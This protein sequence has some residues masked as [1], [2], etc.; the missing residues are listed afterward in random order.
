MS[1]FK[2][3]QYS[4]LKGMVEYKQNFCVFLISFWCYSFSSLAL[5]LMFKPIH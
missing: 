4:I 2:D 1:L 3:M 5:G